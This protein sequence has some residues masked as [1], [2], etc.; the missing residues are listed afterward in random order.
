VQEVRCRGVEVADNREADRDVR[1]SCE[2]VDHGYIQND[3][4]GTVCD[5]FD[6]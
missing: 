1:S 2:K 6:K 4:H 3:D 5:G